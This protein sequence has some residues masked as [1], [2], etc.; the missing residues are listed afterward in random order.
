MLDSSRALAYESHLS[1]AADPID[2]NGEAEQRFYR[3]DLPCQIHSSLSSAF[4]LDM[5]IQCNGWGL[6]RASRGRER[7]DDSVDLRIS[8]FYKASCEVNPFDF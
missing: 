6:F 7:F 1:A 2:E 3:P 4:F 8:S 5:T